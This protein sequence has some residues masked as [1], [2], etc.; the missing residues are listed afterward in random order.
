VTTR[1]LIIKTGALG[2]VVRTTCL[3]PALERLFRRL[4]L[5]W[6]TSRPAWPLVAWHPA[7]ARVAAIDDADSAPWRG[8]F[9][10]WVI[11]LDDDVECCE[12]ATSLRAGRLSG[13][14]MNAKG[15]RAYT[16]DTEPW[17]GMGLLRPENEGG[18]EEANRR[19][20]GN[21]STF[22][23]LLYKGLGLPP[24]VRPPS[25]HI[26]VTAV[27]TATEWLNNAVGPAGSFI[28]GTTTRMVRCR[29]QGLCI[30]PRPMPSFFHA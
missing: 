4:E 17:F 14:Y 13:G 25:V 18:L 20:R 29:A 19:K 8:R 24:P 16:S 3:I 1:V 2:D 22:G 26:P 27:R 12:L 21:R 10:D 23:A 9:Y 11:S 30:K 15:L 7:V 28:V 5:T 6:V